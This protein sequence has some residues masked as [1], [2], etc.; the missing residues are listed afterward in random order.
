MI[1]L[2][3]H[4]GSENHGCE[5]LVRSTVDIIE[6]PIRLFSQHSEQ[7]V[8]Y[9]LNEICD[10]VSDIDFEVKRGS[11]TWFMSA[12]Q[13]KLSGKIDLLMKYRR[14]NLI[15]MVSHNDICLSIGGDNYCYAGTDK[16]AA[17]NTNIRKKGAKTV[18]WGCSVEPELIKQPDIAK[19][20]ASFDLITARETISYEALRKVN[21]NTVLVADSAFVLNRI[22][23]DL[24]EGWIEGKMIGINASPLILQSGKNG[25]LI[26]DAYKNLIQRILDI[27]DCSIAL[28]PHVVW[29]DNDDRIPLK[30]L[31]DL[32]SETG[33][34]ILLDDHNCMEIK[35]YIARCRM[36]IGART[37]ATIA[38]YSSCG[39]TLVIGYS[40][41][42][43]GI[44]KDL[45]GTADNYVLSVQD[46]TSEKELAVGFDWFYA[47]ENE[48]RGR[49]E[50]IIPQYKKQV[51][52]GVKQLRNMMEDKH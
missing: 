19:D 8:K 48:I 51:Y 30:V 32:F 7:D 2:Y 37:H 25:K 23:C 9:G 10:I 47:H 27:T 33:R 41:K 49:L 17:I 29:E 3:S 36:F 11:L 24:P 1:C 26:L 50:K 39:P 35:G 44:A 15:E 13:T 42:S 20:I 16:L 31:Y 28:I 22:D 46:I 52:K 45:F 18:F 34:V 6:Q 21:P 38:A 43:R 12:V 40:V 14:K 5:A 4:G